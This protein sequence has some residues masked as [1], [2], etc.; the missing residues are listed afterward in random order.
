MP[1][2][3]RTYVFVGLF[4]NLLVAPSLW[5]H[6]SSTVEFMGR[7][8][9]RYTLVLLSHGVLIA[10]WLVS[11][12]FVPLLQRLLRHVK[13]S[14][15]VLLVLSSGVFLLLLWMISLEVQILTYLSLNWLM[16]T[17]IITD[18][19]PRERTSTRFVWVLLILTTVLMMLPLFLTAFT[20]SGYHP[21]E[22]HYTDYASTFWA[23]GMLYDRAWLET[24]YAIEPGWPWQLAAYGWLLETFGY[25]VRIGRTINFVSYLLC[26][27][28]LY[29]VTAKLYTPIA[30][31]LAAL[32]A[33]LSVAFI[34]EW[35][36][37]PNH[38]LTPV[39]AWSLFL[40]ISARQAKQPIV[41][42]LLHYAVGLIAT[43]SLN[44]HAAGVVFAA[45]YS[46]FYLADA[47]WVR[48]RCHTEYSF[49]WYGL[50]AF[51]LGAL[52]GTV[53]YWFSNIAPV[54][55]LS[56]YL[57]ILGEWDGARRSPLFF[58]TWESLFE[59]MLILAAVIYLLFRRQAADRFILAIIGFTVLA[60]ILLDTQGYIW[61]FGPFYFIALGAFIE[62]VSPPQTRH[63]QVAISA[64][65]FIMVIQVS[66][67]FVDWSVT[68]TWLRNR[69][70]PAYFYNELK[71]ILPQHVTA[72]DTIYTTHQLIWVFPHTSQPNIITYGAEA[73]GMKRFNV[74][75]PVEVWE[76]VQPTVIIFVEGQMSY[77]QGMRTYLEH[78]PFETCEIFTIQ[79][80]VV[81]IL[82]PDCALMSLSGD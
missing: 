2:S 28:G 73:E 49:A 30:G 3:M 34:P 82:R 18:P 32:L 47:L 41:H 44:I 13:P 74:D 12:W 66:T 8:S 68:R 35:D 64:I 45:G 39:G 26:F 58:Y 70:L 48:L 5:L 72:D 71:P 15:T 37:S 81:T 6:Q 59:R 16:F 62:T 65:I 51:G 4:L 27:A 36:Y 33:F 76:Q 78:N 1:F 29:A 75:T 55:G 19:I 21:D 22:A 46:L 7:Y 25:T 9:T 50:L 20:I 43:L 77:D 56:V 61:H 67:L 10:M 63:G 57:S 42:L 69:T 23:E 11:V 53:I 17:V 24:P 60:A 79:E 54:G 40:M 38:L 52:T 14:H 80:M 31:G